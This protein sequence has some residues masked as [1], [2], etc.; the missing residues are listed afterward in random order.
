[1]LNKIRVTGL[2]FVLA[3]CVGLGSWAASAGLKFAQN[4]VTRG[5]LTQALMIAQILPAACETEAEAKARV[6][7]LAPHVTFEVLD[8]AHYLALFDTL[9]PKTHTPVP[10]RLIV[11]HSPEKSQVVMLG[12]TKGCL[13]LGGHVARDSHASIIKALGQGI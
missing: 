9:P 5:D 1:M 6:Y 8:A 12:F 10:E 11:A 3:C 7:L 2:C 13:S 4:E